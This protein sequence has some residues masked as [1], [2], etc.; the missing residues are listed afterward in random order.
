MV[1]VLELVVA[2]DPAVHPDVGPSP[3]SAMPDRLG[4]ARPAAPTARSRP[5][6]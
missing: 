1:G 5:T 2:V 3:A 4:D 6:R